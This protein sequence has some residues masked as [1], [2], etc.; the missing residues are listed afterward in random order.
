MFCTL[1]MDDLVSR[2]EKINTST[3]DLQTLG[4]ALDTALADIKAKIDAAKLAAGCAA[5]CLAI[6]TT[7]VTTN[8]DFSRV[9]DPQ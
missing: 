5:T 6:D 3:T 9:S 1:A 8:A 7:N 2:M 4:T